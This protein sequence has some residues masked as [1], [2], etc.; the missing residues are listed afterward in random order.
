MTLLLVFSALLEL[1][2]STYAVVFDLPSHCTFSV[3]PINTVTASLVT[4]HF[5]SSFHLINDKQIGAL[6]LSFQSPN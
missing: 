1:T 6:L 5:L 4:V 3:L 2:A